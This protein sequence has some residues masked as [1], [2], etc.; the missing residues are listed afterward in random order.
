MEEEFFGVTVMLALRRHDS[1]AFVSGTGL[2][3]LDHA[4]FGLR[5]ALASVRR[6]DVL[7]SKCATISSALSRRLVR[8]GRKHPV[9]TLCASN[10]LAER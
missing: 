9:R 2:R 8:R 1:R 10:Q 6:A 4:A 3:D 7:V 5:L